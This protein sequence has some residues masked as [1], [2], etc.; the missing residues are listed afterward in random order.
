VKG[1]KILGFA[2]G[3]ANTGGDKPND[4]DGWSARM[5]WRPDG[6]I[7]QYVYHPDQLDIYGQDFPWNVGGQRLFTTGKWHRVEHR[8]VMNTPGQH[9]GRIQGWLDGVLA[10]DVS[11][12]RFRDVDRYA[13]DLFYFS[14]FFGGNDASW[15][16][17][18][19][20]SVCFD[21]F[22]IATERVVGR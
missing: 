17:T 19:D 6:R 21:D 16:P 9:D 14:T 18:R 22:V 4:Q 15:A 13:I 11:G 7:V 2:G 10:L 12:L 3:A 1:G 8:I 5:M 20:E